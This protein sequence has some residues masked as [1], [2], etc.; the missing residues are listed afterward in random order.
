M[1]VGPQ[2]GWDRATASGRRGLLQK[3]YVPGFAMPDS[4]SS[5]ADIFNGLGSPVTDNGCAGLSDHAARARLGLSHPAPRTATGL[6]VR[7]QLLLAGQCVTSQ[8]LDPHMA[9]CSSH[10][11]CTY[12]QH[13]LHLGRERQSR[14]N[15]WTILQLQ[16]CT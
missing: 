11:V 6:P 5:T 16:Q 1:T 3:Q 12:L 13:G 9:C 8:H 15:A 14:L 2:A 10:A 4:C 7:S